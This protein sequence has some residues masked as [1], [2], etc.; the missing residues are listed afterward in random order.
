[1]KWE[2][3]CPVC[4]NGDIEEDDCFDTDHGTN[5]IIEYYVGHCMA[6]GRS[7]QWERH[8]KFDHQTPYEED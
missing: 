7:F 5:E 6:C 8:Y 4:H 3:E 1:M 2:W